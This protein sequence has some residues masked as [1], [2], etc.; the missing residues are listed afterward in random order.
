MTREEIETREEQIK[1][2]QG[3]IAAVVRRIEGPEADAVVLRVPLEE[4]GRWMAYDL[5]RA[6]AGRDALSEGELAGL[7]EQVREDLLETDVV[8][9]IDFLVDEYVEKMRGSYASFRGFN[10]P[11]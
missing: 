7:Y 6:G 1:A 3:R 8:G 11:S 10:A 5:I 9:E 4:I 2:L